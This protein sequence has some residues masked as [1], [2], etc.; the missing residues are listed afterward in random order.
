MLQDT[1]VKGRGASL[2]RGCLEPNMALREGRPAGIEEGRFRGWDSSE[3]WTG[4]PVEEWLVVGAP[5]Q[6]EL[7]GDVALSR[8]NSSLHLSSQRATGGKG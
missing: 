3:S 4:C 7:H 2:P 8:H 5:D 6:A 1:Q